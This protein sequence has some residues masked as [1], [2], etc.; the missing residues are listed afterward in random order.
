MYYICIQYNTYIYIYVYDIIHI[1][2]IYIYIYIY[3]HTYVY[4]YTHM[5][6]TI[7]SEH[8]HGPKVY[9]S[10]QRQARGL[11]HAGDGQLPRQERLQRA[12]EEPGPWERNNGK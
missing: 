9:T 2:I 4:I 12:D 3:I 5:H 10:P 11:R 1:Y 7:D 8:P 6:Y